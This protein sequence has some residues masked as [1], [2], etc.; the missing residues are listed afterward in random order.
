MEPKSKED[1]EGTYGN[2]FSPNKWEG[3][4][5]QDSP[6]AQKPAFRAWDAIELNKWS[7]VFPIAKSDSIMIWSAFKIDQSKNDT[8]MSKIILGK[9]AAK[10]KD[11]SQNDKTGDSDNFDGAMYW[12]SNAG[13]SK[14]SINTCAKINSAS[15]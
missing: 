5:R 3:S 6:P 10:V 12:A 11:N 1:L 15:P 13:H 8:S 2:N 4:L 7:G 14:W 9:L